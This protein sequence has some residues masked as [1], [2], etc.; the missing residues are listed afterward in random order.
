M[1]RC[2]LSPQRSIGRRSYAAFTAALVVHAAIV[3]LVLW[4]PSHLGPVWRGTRARNV[5]EHASALVFMAPPRGR[6]STPAARSPS[7]AVRGTPESADSR[8]IDIGGA[9]AAALEAPP[10]A[11][12][13]A[14]TAGRGRP[15]G[16]L[17][18]P[19]V[20]PM[21]R[22]LAAPFVADADSL[23]V[24]RGIL[25]DALADVLARESAVFD[26][27]RGTGDARFGLTPGRLHLGR[28]VVPLPVSMTSIQDADPRARRR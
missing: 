28:F 8:G 20:P 9:T 11:D 15:A 23:V 12:S 1:R 3:S 4:I 24:L 17:D 10:L 18:S 27:T 7:A 22:R 14:V 25:H 26:W 21:D 2:S 19:F 16:L 6:Q 13:G 5:P